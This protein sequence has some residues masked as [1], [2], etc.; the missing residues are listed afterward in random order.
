MECVDRVLLPS[1]AR[2]DSE[3][4]GDQLRSFAIC[5]LGGMGKTELAAEYAYSRKDQFEA[6]FWLGAD[7]AKILASNFAQIA[8]RLGLEDDQSDFAASRDIAMGWLS[9]PLKKVAEPD[10]PEN[11]ADWLVIFDNVDN[12]DVL[13]DYWP[14]FG[15]GSVLVTSRD[16]FAKHNLYVEEGINLRPLSSSESEAMMQRLTHV[17]ADTTNR[18]ALSAIAG[19]LDGFPLAIN[20]MSGVFRQLRLSYTDFLKYYNEE[21][22]EGLFDKQTERETADNAHTIRSLATVWALDRLSKGTRALLQVICLLDPDEIPEELLINKSASAKLDGYPTSRGDY[23][24]ARSELVASSLINQDAEH[25]N[26]SLHRLIQETAKARMEPNE[27]VAAFQAAGSLI[28]SAW[29]FQSMK[30]HHSVARFSRCEAIFPSV[31]RLKDGLEPLI[32]ASVDFPLD[33]GLA[34]LFNDTGWYMFERGL[35]DETKPFCDLGLLIGERLQGN[36]GEAAVESI[37]ESH[38]FMGIVLAETNEHALSMAHKK[39]WLSMLEE[40]RLPSGDTVKDY[41]LGYAY[42][43]IGVA[44]GN[45][46]LLDEAAGAFRRSIEIFQSLEDYADTMLGWP[47]PNLGFIYWMQGKLQMAE[48]ALLQILEIHATAWGFDDTNSFK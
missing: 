15:R 8:Q 2:R 22:I 18:N 36:V 40:R 44:Y 14:K 5:G 28:I 32:Q 4:A 9:L 10:T 27:L 37:R 45:N 25:K 43:E 17:K 20:Q 48:E 6:I 46:D 29:P 42:N 34:K 39:K 41:E 23:Y 16:P 47:L 1:S 13:S 19:K 33:I 26:I 7:D 3:D 24:K 21:G 30:E 38:S 35:M 11:V 31:L 12:L